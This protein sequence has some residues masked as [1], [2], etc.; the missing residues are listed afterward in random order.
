M[1][2][3]DCDH[4]GSPAEDRWEHQEGSREQKVCW[5][6]RCEVH[7]SEKKPDKNGKNLVLTDG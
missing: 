2:G 6:E 5:L 7:E 4:Y 1:L 3:L